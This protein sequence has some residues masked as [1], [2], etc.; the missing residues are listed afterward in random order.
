MSKELK[1]CP[2]CGGEAIHSAWRGDGFLLPRVEWEK[3]GCEKCR[4]W[5]DPRQPYGDSHP[6]IDAWNARTPNPAVSELVSA[7]ERIAGIAKRNYGRQN[8]KMAD[9]EPIALAALSK[10]KGE[11]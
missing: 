10:F 5:T 2:H 11:A 3:C 6:A 9:I 7:L 4:I 8:E 1:P